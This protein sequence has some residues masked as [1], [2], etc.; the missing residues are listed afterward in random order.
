GWTVH[1]RSGL[2]GLLLLATLI[3]SAPV[4]AERRRVRLGI[5]P[6]YTLA[7]VDRR[8]P[9]GGGVGA[10]L[11]FGV[12]DALSVRASGFVSFQH[13]SGR[14]LP[15]TAADGASGAETFSPAG[16]LGVFGAFVGLSYALDV[17]R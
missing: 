2:P 1:L 11:A 7:Y 9:S 15:S 3:S 13:A 8:D 5:Q 14:A 17:L 4:Q 16:T 6:I 10:D 12:T